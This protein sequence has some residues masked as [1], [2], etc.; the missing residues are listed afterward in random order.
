[1]RDGPAAANEDGEAAERDVEE[2][3]EGRRR[4]AQEFSGGARRSELQLGNHNKTSL[5][6]APTLV[7]A[8]RCRTCCSIIVCGR[9]CTWLHVNRLSELLRLRV[10]YLLLG[11][12]FEGWFS[13]GES[14]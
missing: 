4:E 7:R 9:G 3:V 6:A 1:M 8:L 13:S 2:E 12:Q 5:Y 14:G 10:D 11:L